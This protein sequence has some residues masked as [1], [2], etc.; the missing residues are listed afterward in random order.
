MLDSKLNFDIH[1]KENP[2][3]VSIDIGRITMNCIHF[4]YLGSLC[5]Q[6]S[7][8]HLDHCDVIY[9]KPRIEEFIDII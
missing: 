6:L 2:S 3:N 7:R 8:P 1:L 5:F 4:I 9:D